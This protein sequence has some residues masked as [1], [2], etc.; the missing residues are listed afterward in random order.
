[1]SLA[2]SSTSSECETP[3]GSEFAKKR[4]SMS[5]MIRSED[6]VRWEALRKLKVL[7]TINPE[8]SFLGSTLADKAILLRNE[9]EISSSFCDAF[10]DKRT[11]TLIKRASSCWRSVKWV[12]QQGH[13]DPLSVGEPVFYAYMGH[14]RE[15]G[16]PT[17]ATSFIESWTF[18]FHV[19][20]LKTPPL[21]M[22]LSPRVRGAAKDMF[23]SKRKLVQAVPLTVRMV[24]ALEQ[25]VQ[26]APYDHWKI[27]AGHLLFCLGASSRFADSLHL[28]SLIISKDDASGLSMSLVEA[29]TGRYKTGNTNERRTRLLPLLSL[30]QF[31][32]AVPWA[33]LWI[34][35][36]SKYNVPTS[37]A[38]PAF[39]EVTNEWLRRPMSTGE[40]SLYLKEMLTGFEFDKDVVQQLGCRSLNV[41]CFRC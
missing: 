4:L 28:D 8:N 9:D 16:A 10:A 24:L 37:P 2:S 22:V 5:S 31:F 6:Q 35:L 11:G 36:R 19:A 25:A 18:L 39:A 40:A 32:A 23:A 12:I 38:L 15:N 13:V 34:N 21:G 1:M 29:D 27:M 14:L 7:L 20:G 30:G 3:L 17:T 26:L 41:P 33:E